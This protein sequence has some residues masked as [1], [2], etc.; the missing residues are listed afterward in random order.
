M[1]AKENGPVGWFYTKNLQLDISDLD[2]L[3]NIFVSTIWAQR[4]F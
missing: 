3:S 2:E 4:G 1:L